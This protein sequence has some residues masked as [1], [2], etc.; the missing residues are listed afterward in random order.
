MPTIYIYQDF[1]NTLIRVQGKGME[2]KKGSH[3]PL[4]PP[5]SPSTSPDS[6]FGL[7][8]L[9]QVLIGKWKLILTTI[10]LSVLVAIFYLL[11]ATPLYETEVILLPPEAQHVSAL[12]IKDLYEITTAEIYGAFL[13]NLKSNSLRRQFYDQNNL[14]A[15]LNSG[16]QPFDDTE[17]F[18]HNFNNLLKVKVGTN[19]EAGI[20]SVSLRGEDPELVKELLNGFVMLAARQTIG[21]IMEGIRRNINNEMDMVNDQIQA[22]RLFAKELR[23]DRIAM[24][25]EQLAIA[26]ELNLSSR[27]NTL[28]WIG[29]GNNIGFTGTNEPLYLRGVKELTAEK[30]ILEKRKNDDPFILDLREKQI[31]LA[32]LESGLKNLH[33]SINNINAARIDQRAS[34][35][36]HPV[37]PLKILVLAQ[38]LVLG[39]ILGAFVAFLANFIEQRSVCPDGKDSRTVA[40]SFS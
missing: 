25:D 31:R 29:E 22:N 5:V 32:E 17:V 19:N 11:I 14:G 13:R 20:V 1:E 4:S 9:W 37:K 24:L 10:T 38:G 33:A 40:S 21:E 36:K 35:P 28:L 18:K 2:G 6:E 26:R 34:L 12:N 16:K 8:D 27:D 7:Q 15:A 30:V 23:L 3:P 39:L